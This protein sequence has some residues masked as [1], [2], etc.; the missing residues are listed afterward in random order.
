[1][2]PLPSL[3][4]IES[5]GDA[6]LV[7]ADAVRASQIGA[8]QRAGREEETGWGPGGTPRKAEAASLPADPVIFSS[9]MCLLSPLPFCLSCFGVLIPSG[10][11]VSGERAGDLRVSYGG[12]MGETRDQLGWVLPP[13]LY[14]PLIKGWLSLL[15]FLLLLPFFSFLETDFQD[16]PAS[17]LR[18]VDLRAIHHTRV[19][20]FPSDF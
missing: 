1:M 15:S 10:K 9:G 13:P 4:E 5:G 11:S 2:A 3:A 7:S 8:Q 18:T 14:H 12:K 20:S 17:A 16:P 19:L 6:G